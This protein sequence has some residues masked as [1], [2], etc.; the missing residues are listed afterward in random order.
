M[1]SILMIP[2][3]EYLF[4]ERS[5]E[6]PNGVKLGVRFDA[7]LAVSVHLDRANAAKL[8]EALAALC[9]PPAEPSDG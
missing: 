6:I 4:A 1:A 9:A 3:G 5:E 2:T 7:K 8:R